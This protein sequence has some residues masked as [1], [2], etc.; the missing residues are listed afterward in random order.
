MKGVS[1]FSRLVPEKWASGLC[2]LSRAYF[3]V[4][5]ELNPFHGTPRGREAHAYAQFSAEQR[6]A[7]AF[8][9]G[10]STCVCACMCSTG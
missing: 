1:P 9:H 6:C 8:L 3:A 10:G 7:S 4:D 5:P 2:R